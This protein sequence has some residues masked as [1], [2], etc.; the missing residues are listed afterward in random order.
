V[1]DPYNNLISPNNAAGNQKPPEIDM[2][3]RYNTVLHSGQTMMVLGKSEH[4]QKIL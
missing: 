4:I 1:R 2:D 3:V